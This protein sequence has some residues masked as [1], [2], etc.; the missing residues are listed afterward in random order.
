MSQSPK[1][2]PCPTCGEAIVWDRQARWRPFCSE[3][4]R[5]IDLG[6]WLSEERCLPA[7]DEPWSAGEAD[8]DPSPGAPS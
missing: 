2:V 1:I 5:L 7:E 6:E 3:R 8:E 4:C